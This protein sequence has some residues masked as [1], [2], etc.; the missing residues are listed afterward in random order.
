MKKALLLFL[1][2]FL[3]AH[4][5]Q[6]SSLLK[7]LQLHANHDTIRCSILE[8]LIDTEND[9]HKWIVYNKELIG[10][11]SENLSKPTNPTTA[12]AFKRYQALAYNNQGA[13]YIFANDYKKAISYYRLSL[14]ISQSIDYKTGNALALQ[15]IGTAYDFLGKLDST[16]VY[17]N[18]AYDQARMDNDAES[19]AYIETDLG[20]AYNHLGNNTLAIKYNLRALKTF[21]KLND[22][23]GKERT[24]F[25]IGRIFDKQKA[26]SKSI[27]Y[28][29]VCL[30][31]NKK[32]QDSFRIALAE[33]A[34]A[35]SYLQLGKIEQ[36]EKHLEIS[37]KLCLESDF[38]EQLANCDRLYGDLEIL[39]SNL[40]QA[41]TFYQQAAN[42]Y[43]KQTALNS[44]QQIVL[45]MADL[46]Y[47]RGFLEL[48]E[49]QSL[50]SFEQ[51]KKLGYPKL[52]QES[53]VLLSKLYQKKQDFK[54][55]FR[56]KEIAYAIAEESYFDEKN[57][58]ALNATYQYEDEKKQMRLEKLAQE[59]KISELKNERQQVILYVGIVSVLA[60]LLFLG[61]L[62]QRFRAKKQSQLFESR[63]QIS[64]SQQKATESELKAL[65]SQMNPHFIFNA[66]N[67][68][69]SLFLFG[70]KNEANKM[71]ANFTSLTRDILETSTKKRISIETEVSILTRYLELEKMRFKD[72]FE[73]SINYSDAIEPD[74]HQIPPML[75]QPFLEN[76]V[77]H[78][79]LHKVGLKKVTLDFDIDAEEK[80]IICVVQDNGIG[81]K[82]SAEINAENPHKRESFSTVATLHRLE[83]IK[84]DDTKQTLIQY[85]DIIKNDTTEGTRVTI[86]IPTGY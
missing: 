67:S 83:L 51:S 43:K 34:L 44:Y 31:I 74:Y 7:Q 27:Q 17:L 60:V 14:K 72:G 85:D 48:S 68:I 40:P 11:V 46:N 8:K 61:I 20:F 22:D 19:M 42:V 52:Q 62:F 76:A 32:N 23:S 54:N 50:E 73:Y 25:A 37:K 39:R 64:E 70:D 12:K 13:Y 86:K 47:N 81:R 82:K 75:L 24:C 53:A 35:N 63:L 56:Y 65:R 6:K 49:N 18:L 84:E 33:N 26:Y 80:F 55:A 71:M 29:K 77:N 57:T 59:K 78:G 5:Q 21:E 1:L 30:E 79:L 28:Y 4:S 10:I 16:V 38:Q 15:N 2:G 36:A 66:L 9:H 58:I 3:S 45:K 69:Q 41:Y